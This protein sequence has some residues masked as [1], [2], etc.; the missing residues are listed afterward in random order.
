MI[1]AC[2]LSPL[3]SSA[4]ASLQGCMMA[5]GTSHKDSCRCSSQ[6][7]GLMSMCQHVGSSTA[8]QRD[9]SWKACNLSCWTGCGRPHALARAHKAGHAADRSACC[10][11][12]PAACGV[13]C[14]T[15]PIGCCPC[16]D[17]S[18]A[19]S[20]TSCYCARLV[21]YAPSAVSRRLCLTH[22]VACAEVQQT[23]AGRPDDAAYSGP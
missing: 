17:S 15:Q 21:S 19:T 22:C 10:C 20:S 16:T 3:C 4:R 14:Q 12:L 5:C 7:A 1:L 23:A 6:H 8:V 2:K 13:M 11:L 18:K 9:K